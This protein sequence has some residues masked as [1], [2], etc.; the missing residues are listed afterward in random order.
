MKRS[1]FVRLNK[2]IGRTYKY[3]LLFRSSRDGYST[4]AFHNV[5][6][7]KGPTVSIIKNNHGKIIGGY[8]PLSWSSS[9]NYNYKADNEMK[10]FIFSISIG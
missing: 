9:C 8:T 6:D 5:C 3:T 2:W 1:Y 10:S 7:N 4:Y